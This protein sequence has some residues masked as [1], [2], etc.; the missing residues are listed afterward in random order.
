VTAH[1]VVAATR[2]G[3]GDAY[4]FASSSLSVHLAVL[5]QEKGGKGKGPQNDVCWLLIGSYAA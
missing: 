5:L 2:G 3:H 1:G 4:A